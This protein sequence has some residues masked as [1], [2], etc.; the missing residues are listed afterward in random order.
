MGLCVDGNTLRTLIMMCEE[1]CPSS[2][3]SRFPGKPADSQFE[4]MSIEEHIAQWNRAP[5]IS[6][7]QL[8]F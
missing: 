4:H 3:E 6:C 2:V 5:T 7:R 8:Q 1:L